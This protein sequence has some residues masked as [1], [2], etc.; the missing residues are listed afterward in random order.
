MRHAK[1]AMLNRTRPP[2]LERNPALVWQGISLSVAVV[3]VVLLV[4][5]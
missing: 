1:Q 4:L 2:R 5:G 3:I